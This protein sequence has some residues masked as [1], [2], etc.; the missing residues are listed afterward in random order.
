MKK[1]LK[2]ILLLSAVLALFFALFCCSASA[3]DYSAEQSVYYE[4]MTDDGTVVIR[5]QIARDGRWYLFLPANADYSALPLA[6]DETKIAEV[7][8]RVSENTVSIV[9]GGTIDLSALLTG[10]REQPVEV[11]F[12]EN[13]TAKSFQLVLM[14]SENLRSVY[15][16]SDD[17]D[18]FGRDYV[19]ASKSNEEASGMLAVY[20]GEGAL[21]Y[22]GEVKEIK[23]RGNT[24]FEKFDKKPY[25]LKL[26]KKTEL[27][28]GA[29][30]SKKWLLLANASDPTLIRNSALFTVS[31]MVGLANTIKFEP[32][33][34]YFDG[35]Y[36]GTY[37]LT[38]KVEIGDGR[39]EISET[40]DLIEDAN[41]D[42]PAYDDPSVKIISRVDGTELSVV[43][44]PGSVRYVENLIEPA[45]PEGANHH[46]Y[47][48]E[49]ELQ[50]RY[51]NEL[52]GF[53]TDRS[54]RIVTK[55]PEYLTYEQGMYIADFW[56]EFEDAVYSKDGYNAVTG[57]YY[58][59]YCD[60]DSLVKCYVLNEYVKNSDYYESSTYFYLPENS[61][62]LICGPL[63]DYDIAF[64]IGY[65]VNRESLITKPEYFYC[66]GKPFA[67][68]LLQIPSF[69]A[70][71]QELTA[72]GGEVYEAI[73]S[74]TGESGTV[75]A[76]AG[77][78][79][80][81]Q[82]MN[83]K[84]WDIEN[85]D[86][87]A[88]TQPAGTTFESAVDTLDS[89]ISVRFQWLNEQIGQWT[90][91]DYFIQTKPLIDMQKDVLQKVIDLLNSLVAQLNAILKAF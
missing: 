2:R 31:E 66:G 13:S 7:A 17:P 27:I 48:L 83:Y 78:I 37:L 4:Q 49:F 68:A 76:L 33:D 20:S 89:F 60:L 77:E 41:K 80:G 67:R 55:T 54:Q 32:V 43:D 24:S 28:D 51:P 39:I 69:R 86:M 30:K 19:D 91:D 47:L 6:Y 79:Y 9:N 46:A 81:S 74:L 57:K 45:Y 52:T 53:V 71:V 88:V 15:Y 62:Q 1:Y 8:L 5:P 26:D 75:R 11:L 42:T 12:S 36:R 34:F 61:D 21:D 40:D 35:E 70:K 29:G 25:Q 18:N 58:Y 90:D 64:G 73:Q 14:K 65:D 10:E 44:A 3:V 82:A 16:V 87:I 50:N 85:K 56:Q 59:D 22:Y 72:P 63:W 38:E 84:L 23:G